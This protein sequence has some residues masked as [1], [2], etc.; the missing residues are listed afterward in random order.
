MK[1]RINRQKE[2]IR[3]YD[4]DKD[5][6]YLIF[7]GDKEDIKEWGQPYYLLVFLGQSENDVNLI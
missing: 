2:S 5:L 6:N 1:L 3:I 7:I 4:I